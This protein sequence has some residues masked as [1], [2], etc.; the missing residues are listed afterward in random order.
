MVLSSIVVPASVYHIA[1]GDDKIVY[2]EEWSFSGSVVCLIF[3]GSGRLVFCHFKQF[4]L[5]SERGLAN[6]YVSLHSWEKSK[7]HLGGVNVDQI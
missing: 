3:L 1:I 7:E 6:K 4:G 2:A 5:S